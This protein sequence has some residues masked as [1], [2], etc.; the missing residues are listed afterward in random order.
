MEILL[1]LVVK[2]R[3]GKTALFKG[4]KICLYGFKEAR[5]QMMN[6]FYKKI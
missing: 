6:V 1:L 2:N 4:I 5:Y 3:A